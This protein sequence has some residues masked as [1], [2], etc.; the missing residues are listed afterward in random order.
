[1]SRR[2]CLR[3]LGATKLYLNSRS[4]D[5]AAHGIGQWSMEEHPVR[6]HRW[7]HRLLP[8]SFI[9]FE[10]REFSPNT[11]PFLV[12][13]AA[14]VPRNIPPANTFSDGT[15]LLSSFLPLPSSSSNR[16]T[17]QYVEIQF[18]ESRSIVRDCSVRLACCPEELGERRRTASWML[19]ISKGG[20]TYERKM[21]ATRSVKER[22]R[23][24][25]ERSY[26][27]MLVVQRVSAREC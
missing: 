17:K 21:G 20:E 8:F 4:W 6:S 15:F 16:G 22:E 19:A 7:P 3:R 14:T 27:P 26:S 18:N 10:R 5:G 25:E 23:E 1:M 2:S 9:P 12:P 13:A 11:S 24:R